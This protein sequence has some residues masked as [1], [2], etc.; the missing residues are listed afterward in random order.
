MMAAVANHN[1]GP[2][3]FD[4]HPDD[5][6]SYVQWHIRDFLQGVRGLK[7]DQIGIYTIVLLLIYDS[8]GMLRDE[9]RFVAGHCQVDVRT[10]RKIRQQLIDAGKVY[11][12]DGYL[13]NNRAQAEIAKFCEA[14][15][16]KRD[17]ALAREEKKREAAA[18][19]AAEEAIAPQLNDHNGRAVCAELAQGAHTACAQ[20]AQAE[21]TTC[22]EKSENINEIKGATITPLP[23][24]SIQKEKEREK[25]K[26]SPL[27][28][29]PPPARWSGDALKEFVRKIE[30]EAGDALANPAS[31]A[32]LLNWSTILSWIQA[33]ADP[34]FDIL[35]AV[36]L[37]AGQARQRKQTIRSWEYFTTA[38]ADCK[39]RREQGLPAVEI[40]TKP[41]Q[42]KL[43]RW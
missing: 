5:R 8:M 6:M 28:P 36:K 17:A 34:E 4:R 32:G 14:A 9:D 1:Q 40:R 29:P 12:A 24:L 42:P 43:S 25:E 19:K 20:P 7:P 39:K 11:E 41:A 15:K 33:G 18:K 22:S 16:K 26:E 38:V 35:P 21:H 37:R 31:S 2:P 30:N 27:S 13:Y 10:Y 23:Q 3:L